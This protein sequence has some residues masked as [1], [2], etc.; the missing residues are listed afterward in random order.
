MDFKSEFS[1]ITQ[2]PSCFKPVNNIQCGYPTIIASA[3]KKIISFNQFL[4]HVS[5][6]LE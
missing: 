3:S 4:S 6:F 5:H 2:S 1:K